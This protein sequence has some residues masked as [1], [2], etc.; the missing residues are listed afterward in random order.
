VLPLD[1]TAEAHRLQEQS[2][3]GLSGVVGGKLVIEP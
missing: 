2:T 3:V 1:H